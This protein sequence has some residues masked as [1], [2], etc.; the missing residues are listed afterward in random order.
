VT[1]T[2]TGGAV[3]NKAEG[4][5]MV[6]SYGGSGSKAE[7]DLKGGEIKAGNT[8]VCGGHRSADVTVSGGTLK[9]KEIALGQNLTDEG[10]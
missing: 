10:D 9:A 6:G 7:L 1:M 5:F 3:T 4:V 8:F 2:V